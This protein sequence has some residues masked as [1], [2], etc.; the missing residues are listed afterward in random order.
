MK[1]AILIIIFAFQVQS[2]DPSIKETIWKINEYIE[3]AEN[4]EMEVIYSMYDNEGKKIDG[5]VS[6]VRRSN[7]QIQMLQDNMESVINKEHIIVVDHQKKYIMIRQVDQY[8]D[9]FNPV[10]E[11]ME[12]A[13]SACKEIAT[14]EDG[15]IGSINMVLSNYIY[16]RVSLQYHIGDYQLDRITLYLNDKHFL[17]EPGE[18]A[19]IEM[20]FEVK[21]ADRK[22]DP[23]HFSTN[24]F[25]YPENGKWTLKER[26]AGYQLMEYP[27]NNN[28]N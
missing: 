27:K 19:R 6:T 23:S 26:Y 3:Q 21:N 28:N 7:G 15:G 13:L 16:D 1:A 11:Y 18:K 25:I 22:I 4:L 20:K 8:L 12:S 5:M 9:Q 24:R 2:V 14:K 10:S 17:V